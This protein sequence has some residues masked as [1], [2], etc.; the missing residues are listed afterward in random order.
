MMAISES[1]SMIVNIIDDPIPKVRQ[2]A[3]FVLY[4]I[5]EF[6]PNLIIASAE[7]LD[8]FVNKC[9]IHL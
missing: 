3:A 9:I 6:L 8:L 1:Y 7:N 5:A 4:K 2:T